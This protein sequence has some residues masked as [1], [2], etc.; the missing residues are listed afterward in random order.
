MD[1]MAGRRVGW[2]LA[3]CGWLMRFF[4][5]FGSSINQV[6]AKGSDEH[7]DNVYQVSKVSILI[8]VISFTT[9]QVGRIYL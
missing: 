8:L 6:L 9:A 5:A 3:L 2:L 4:L 1:D 7:D